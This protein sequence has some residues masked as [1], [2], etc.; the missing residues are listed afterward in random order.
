MIIETNKGMFTVLKGDESKI[1][2]EEKEIKVERLIDFLH[3]ILHLAIRAVLDSGAVDKKLAYGEDDTSDTISE[4][5]LCRAI[6]DQLDY[7]LLKNI[8]DN[9]LA[10]A[11]LSKSN[12]NLY[13]V[14]SPFLKGN[15]SD[16]K[17]AW[18]MK[19]LGEYTKT[20]PAVDLVEIIFSNSSANDNFSM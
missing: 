14:L 1:N 9:G 8:G 5:T 15:G 10:E 12:V 4:E 18:I 19:T 7:I 20:L 11:L 2:F 13:D 3:E 6:S 16:Y 17:V